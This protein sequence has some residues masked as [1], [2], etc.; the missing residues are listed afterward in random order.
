MSGC[1]L[2]LG[3]MGANGYGRFQ[4][5]KRH[6]PAHRAAWMLYRGRIPEGLLVCHRCDVRSCVNPDHLFLGT[7]QDNALDA[8]RKG[9]H[10][11]TTW[12]REQVLAIRADPRSIKE[13]AAA[14]DRS[15]WTISALVN[16]IG[17]Q[18]L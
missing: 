13:I 5:Q 8:V 3:P 16:R 18:W 1:T 10:A 7:Y 4:F 2:W 11:G 17:W 15:T 9:R 14:Y 6:W 12:T